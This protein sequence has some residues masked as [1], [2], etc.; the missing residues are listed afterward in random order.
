MLENPEY[1]PLVKT[2]FGS[3]KAATMLRVIN[4]I[5]LLS[6]AL[7][8]FIGGYINKVREQHMKYSHDRVD[9]RLARKTN[10]SDIWTLVLRQEGEKALSLGEMHSN[11]DLFMIAGTETTATSKRID[12]LS[13]NQPLHNGK[14]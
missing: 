7:N 14:T 1:I 3:L 5:Q 10:R 6:S 9:R 13:P 2:I 12:I 11:S 8:F 4:S